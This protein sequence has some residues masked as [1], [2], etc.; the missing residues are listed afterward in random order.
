MKIGCLGAA[1][2][3]PNAIVQPATEL[4]MVTLQAVASSDVRRA[5]NYAE[6]YKFV[7]VLASY[8]EV[9][10]ADNIDIVYNA[11][12][13]HLHA[14]WTIR[15]LE[16]GKHV[17]CEKPM[18]MNMAEAS[19]VIA[20]ARSSG[21][22]VIEAFHCR[23]HPA[24]EQM[25]LWLSSGK[26]GNVKDIRA[27]FTVPINNDSGREIRHFPETGGGA[28]MD[29]GCYPLHWVL[30]I[31]GCG[32]KL[33]TADA[34]LNQFG[35]DE[36]LSAKLH[37]DGGVTAD[38]STSMAG[39]GIFSA[40]LSIQGESGSIEFSNPL[41]P[42][43]GGKLQLFSDRGNETATISRCSTYHYQLA[44]IVN[45]I[46][47]GTPLATE[48]DAIILQQ[49]MMDRIYYAAGLGDLRKSYVN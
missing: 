12:P 22:R 43:W 24:Y 49:D 41:V 19:A 9:I 44:A 28:M 46:K 7:E 25:L 11:L 15:A 47:Q 20:A 2:I 32:A 39:G 8:Q 37:F 36:T 13:N 21:R 48:G 4:D 42:N 34:Q 29:L 6:K 31:T 14:K 33:I 38:I 5:Q 40:H 18:A 23:Y 26:I 45:A 10:S 27:H 3:T 1:R 30:S 35:V 17:I 16:S